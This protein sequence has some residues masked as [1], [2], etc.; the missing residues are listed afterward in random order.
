MESR[1]GL[2]RRRALKHQLFFLTQQTT[3]T[4]RNMNKSPSSPQF[5]PVN[6]RPAVLCA[7]CVSAIASLPAHGAP[8]A[9]HIS[10]GNITVIQNDNSNNVVSVT[11][12]LP[13]SINDFRLRGAGGPDSD[14]LA[15]L[16]SK[17]DFAVQIGPDATNQVQFGILMSSVAENGRDS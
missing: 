5:R 10:A 4:Q 11:T 2:Q 3:S 6:T 17:G 14:S 15:P 13:L 7:I 9:H 8:T 16:N 12:T 1:P